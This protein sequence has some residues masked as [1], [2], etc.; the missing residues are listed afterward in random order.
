MRAFSPPLHL[1]DLPDELL[2][3]ILKQL[4]DIDILSSFSG[5]GN[6]R[7][8]RLTC[9]KTSPTHLHFP[10][11]FLSDSLLER[12][13]QQIFAQIHH[14]VESL[15]L[16]TELLERVLLRDHFPNLTELTLHNF[17]R[18]T[19]LHHFTGETGVLL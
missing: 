3:L 19:S 9:R 16:P 8:H 12:L 5:I 7:L 11:N 14:R 6:H 15:I 2:L 18:D 10:L 1:L 17:Q 4:D 13:T